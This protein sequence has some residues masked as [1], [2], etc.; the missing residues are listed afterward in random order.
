MENSEKKHRGI[1]PFSKQT[2]IIR[3][4]KILYIVFHSLKQKRNPEFFKERWGSTENKPYLHSNSIRFI[5]YHLFFLS[6]KN[7]FS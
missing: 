2:P 6:L 3:E 1:Y 7:A 4:P 5:S